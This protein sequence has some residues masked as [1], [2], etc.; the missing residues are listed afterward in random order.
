MLFAERGYNGVSIADVASEAAVAK[1]SV[2][3]HFADKD[4]LWCEVV[5]LLWTEVD[6]FYR[7]KWPRNV[8]P[9]RDTIAA[10]LRLFVEAALTWPAYVRIPFIEGA[11]PSWRSERLADR[12]FGAHVRFLDA[13]LR[14]AQE[15]GEIP[16][17]DTVHYQTLLTSSVSVLV[18]QA[19]MWNRA[20]GG[21]MTDRKFLDDHIEVIINLT[22]RSN[23]V[24]K[25][26]ENRLA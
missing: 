6:N 24:D 8:P 18:A 19:A 3:Y 10:G 5:D 26:T 23:T 25:P 12:H 15:N 16:P 11:T 2:L 1:P 21:N 14:T 20:F 13:A 7:A 9:R 4:A 17:G 22:F